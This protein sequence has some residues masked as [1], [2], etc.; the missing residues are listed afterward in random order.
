MIGVLGSFTTFSTFGYETIELLRERSFSLALGNVIAQ[1]G[2]GLLAVS[3]GWIAA[4][5]LRN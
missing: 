2:L 1:V 4:R 3:A 5:A